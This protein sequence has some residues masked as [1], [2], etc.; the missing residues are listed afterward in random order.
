MRM[1]IDFHIKGWAPT[2]V[3]KQ[4]PRETRKWPIVLSVQQ[5]NVFHRCEC[6]T[7]RAIFVW[8]SNENARTKQKQ[9]T[10][11]TRTIWLVY[12][13]DSN[14][15]G[16]WL[17]KRTLGWKNFVPEE[18]SRNCFDVILQHDWTMEQ[19]LLHIRVFF[20]GKTKSPCFVLF[21]YWLIK[22]IT[23][24][25]G[26]HFSRSYENRSMDNDESGLAM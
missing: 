22:Q 16:F 4:R 9:Q 3:L 20:G 6:V 18:L 19:C 21:I 1:K 17:V 24:T 2:L 15:P 8:P 26:N 25:Y 12:R 5:Q 14:A 7:I 23:N 13:T 10:N 11:G